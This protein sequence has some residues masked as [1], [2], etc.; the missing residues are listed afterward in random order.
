MKSWRVSWTT[1]A[2]LA[3]CVTGFVTG[4][5]FIPSKTWVVLARLPW[6]AIAAFLLSIG[7]VAASAALGP[8]VRRSRDEEDER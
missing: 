6:E 3:V 4:G 5:V 2:A 8:V 1:V 7:G